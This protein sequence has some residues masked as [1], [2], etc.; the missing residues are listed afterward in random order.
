MKTDQARSCTE[1]GKI[2]STPSLH[3]TQEQRFWESRLTNTN[4]RIYSNIA[5][6]P[7]NGY[8]YLS[9][10][11]RYARV[12]CAYDQFLNGGRL[13][14]DKSLGSPRPILPNFGCTKEYNRSHD[15]GEKHYFGCFWH[16][17]L[18]RI[19]CTRLKKKRKQSKVDTPN[20]WSAEGV[21]GWQ[22][23]QM[24]MGVIT[25]Q[26]AIHPRLDVV[27][28]NLPNFSE[29]WRLKSAVCKFGFIFSASTYNT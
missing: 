1:K 27:Y 8:V 19:L 6:S 9:Q 4:L 20:K 29:Y 21:I 17:T 16:F 11:I 26:L 25:Y 3:F 7:A 2:I 28:R 24:Y 14:A 22:H 5:L 12:W 10:L 18:E 23:H 13:A 15:S